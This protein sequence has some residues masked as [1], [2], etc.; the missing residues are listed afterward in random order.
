MLWSSVFPEDAAYFAERLA[1]EGDCGLE[2]TWLALVDGQIVSAAQVFP[3]WAQLGQTSVRIGGIGNVATRPDYRGRGLAQAILNAQ[4]HWMGANGVAV[5]ILYT[6]IPAFYEPLGWRIAPREVLVVEGPALAALN[7]EP[8]TSYEVNQYRTSDAEEVCRLYEAFNAGRSGS[9][10][11]DLTYVHASS[12]RTLRRGAFLLARR[13]GRLA[14]Y[15]RAVPGPDKKVQIC[16]LCYAEGDESAAPFLVQ[17]LARRSEGV[18]RL[19][20]GVPADH[21]L[22]GWVARELA[23][24]KRVDDVMC[25]I[26]DPVRLMAAWQESG[27]GGRETGSSDDT[28]TLA[29][30]LLAGTEPLHGCTGGALNMVEFPAISACLPIVWGS[31]AF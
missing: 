19:E 8:Q 22:W 9:R 31:D 16:E 5:S 27:L 17:Q 12:T 28:A 20:M 3:Y 29:A 23:T 11:R 18:E 7:A 10:I 15:V 26:V 1:A 6:G 24:V 4:I 14:G 25:R 13:N 2:T 21:H 30:L